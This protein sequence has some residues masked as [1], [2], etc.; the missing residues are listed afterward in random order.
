MFGGIKIDAADK[1]FSIFIRSRAG[2]KCERCYRQ[3]TP[4][5]N[6]LHCSHFWGRRNESTRFEPD[7]ASA[8]CYGCHQFFTSH[9]V[10]HRDW[11][12]KK[13]GE[14]RFNLLTLQAHTARKKD[15]KLSLIIVKELV[16]Q[17]EPH[18]DVSEH[19]ERSVRGKAT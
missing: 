12:F 18:S 7:N 9:P 16:K 14:K 4:P 1:L 6:A 11:V 15:R 3:Y 13:L 10:E 2:W 19:V 17:Y 5:T 8:H